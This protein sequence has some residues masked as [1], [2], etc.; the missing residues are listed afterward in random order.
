MDRE[1]GKMYVKSQ[2][3][4]YLKGKGI[5]TRRPFRCLNPEHTDRNPSMSLDRN[6]SSGPHCKCFSCGAYYDTFDLIAIEYG[7]TDEQ[8]IFSKG[9]E[10]FGLQIDGSFHRSTAWE[11]FSSEEEKR[12]QYQK[13]AKKEQEPEASY[14]IADIPDN[15]KVLD[16]TE[17]VE[18]AHRALMSNDN[19]LSYLTDRG[20]SRRIID[21]YKLAYCPGGHNDLLKAY[22]EHQAKGKKAR[23]Y[24]LIFPYL[25]EKGR[26]GYFLSEISDRSQTDEYNGKY[27]KINKGGAGEEL[28]AQLFNERYLKAD[29]PPVIFLCEGIYD[30]LSVEE[31]GGKAI[32]FVGTADRRFLGLCK[33]YGPQT[34]FVIS[35][36][37]DQAG[38]AATERVKK[39]LDYLGLPYIVRTAES[40][41]DFNDALRAD[42]EV[43]GSFVRRAG[44]EALQLQK[45]KDRQE[46][47]AYMQTSGLYALESLREKIKRSRTAAFYPTGFPSLDSLLDGGLYGG[48]LYFVGAISS[49]GKT[50]LCLQIMDNIAAAGNDVLIFSLEMS[51]EEL[52]AKSV[53]R[54]TL[55]K[56]LE[57]N[58]SSAQAKTVRGIMTGTRYCNYSPEELQLIDDAFE[59]YGDYAGE[60]VFIHEGVGDLGAAEVREIA[61]RHIRVTGNKPVILIDYIQILAPYNDRASDKQNTD[62]AVL[63]LKR[64][65][66][67][68]D[69]P[70]L[71]ISS[72]NR[73]NYTQPV[74]MASFK[75]SGAVEYSSDVLM[76]VQYLGMDWQEG[77]GEK[78]RNARLRELFAEQIQKGRS[79]FGQDLQL[80]ILKNRNGGKGELR[81]SFFPMFNYFTEPGAGGFA[82][83]IGSLDD[84]KAAL[85]PEEALREPA[86]GS[87]DGWQELTEDAELP[88]T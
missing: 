62:K 18:E 9:Y 49:L 66:R 20:L 76:G 43:F 4:S 32:A 79:G 33:K 15:E 31:V 52:A 70:V 63:E 40:G 50:T 54:H 2:L 16:L 29:T 39:G 6:S 82:Y 5:D 48:S 36:D 58:K 87:D 61:E 73:D 85:I 88:F 23:L 65:A 55:L 72:F 56:A 46:R 42:R 13:E 7:L 27:R 11:D 34:S 8:E 30:A 47:E 74:N 86:A 51:K 17:G 25:D 1:Q 14:R 44:E 37:N 68:L 41:K 12:Q 60:H 81:L 53:S 21:D 3:E 35:L 59:A 67:D 80:K 22:P 84:G 24:Q 19:L 45:D 69:I 83:D 28:P 75:E 38:S 78:A 77:E 71:G 26:A 10:L 64:I 57:K